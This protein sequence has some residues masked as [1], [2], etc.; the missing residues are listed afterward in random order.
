MVHE[1][2]SIPSSKQKGTLMNCR[3]GV[4][5]KVEK[6]QKKNVISKVCIIL[7]KA[8]FLQAMRGLSWAEYLTSA[9][10]AIPC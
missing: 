8:S 5:L 9:D 7:G 4:F 10:E 3:K 1:L 2:V 6:G